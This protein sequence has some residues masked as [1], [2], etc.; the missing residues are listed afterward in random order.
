MGI[1]VFLV[2][3]LTSHLIYVM[4]YPNLL[5]I[6]IIG[7]IGIKSGSGNRVV[8]R[9]LAVLAQ[10]LAAVTSILLALFASFINDPIAEEL[11]NHRSYLFISPKPGFF[12]FKIFF[13]FCFV[14]SNTY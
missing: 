10:I 14:C 6:T 12:H 11:K 9:S 7:I 5:L 2:T 8:L 1:I 3:F 4:V 13:S